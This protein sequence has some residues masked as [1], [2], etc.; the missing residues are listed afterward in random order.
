ME[1]LSLEKF[2]ELKSIPLFKGVIVSDSMEPV[3]KVGEKIV[4]DIGNMDIKRFD[5]IV[6][7][8]EGKLIAHYLWDLNQRVEP[9]L[10]RTRSFKY[11]NLDHPIGYELYMGKV[12]SHRLSNWDR[13]KVYFS[14]LF[15]RLTR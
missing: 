13:A 8:L 9:I 6:F 10:F 2:Q 12:I 7:Y 14:L 4:I 5:I 3:L 11:G 1:G 15:S